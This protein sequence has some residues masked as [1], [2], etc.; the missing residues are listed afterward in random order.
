MAQITLSITDLQRL[1]EFCQKNELKQYFIAKDQG[2]YLGASKGGNNNILF[3]FTGCNPDQDEDWYDNAHT[4]F[5]GDDF[6]EQLEIND[7]L[8]LIA[9]IHAWEQSMAMQGKKYKPVHAI[10]WNITQ[11]SISMKAI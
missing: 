8:A 3:Y 1:V 6:G 7:L 11:S 9:R 2:A 5:G 10:R 4:K